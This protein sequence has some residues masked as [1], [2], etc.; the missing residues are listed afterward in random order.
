MR[1]LLAI[2]DSFRS[3]ILFQSSP[4]QLELLKLLERLEPLS[5]P[6]ASENLAIAVADGLIPFSDIENIG[7]AHILAFE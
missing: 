4:E 7:Y 1:G 5:L 3:K 2:D 6:R